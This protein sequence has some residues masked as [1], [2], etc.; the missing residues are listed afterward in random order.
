MSVLNKKVVK[1]VFLCLLFLLCNTA[2]SASIDEIKQ[3]IEA[4]AQNKALLEKEIEQYQKLLKEIGGEVDTLSKAIKTIEATE[5]KTL[6]D[7]KLTENNINQ[8]E[9]EI[10]RLAY[11]IGGKEKDIQADSKIVYETLNEINQIDSSSIIIQLLSQDNLSS[12]WSDM[13]NFYIIQNKIRDKLSELKDTKKA[14]EINKK[15]T[16][17]KKRELTSLKSDL[18]DKKAIL[19]ISKKEKNKLLANTKNKESNY[20]TELDKKTALKNAFD[21]ELAQF[22]S[23]LKFA[24]DPNSIPSAGKGILSW[25]LDNVYITQKFGVTSDSGRLYTTG[26][27]NGVDF[28]AS[29]GT[30]VKATLSGIVEGVGDTDLVCSGASYGK[31]ILIT[32]NNGLSTLYG[33]LS[34]IKVK[35]G[36]K[37]FTGDTI[38]YSGSTG[39][40]TGP[41]LHL[42]LFAS[43]G[44]KIMSKKSAVCKG[45]YTLPMADMRAY[46]DPLSYL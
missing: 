17:D 38:G 45:T 23:E 33:H 46:L 39:Y 42:G 44:V 2:Y 16:E 18:L 19:E 11:D 25:P 22:E 37:V 3:K 27:H 36:D 7:I 13:E 8:A 40:S 24:I 43:Q 26:S 34:L 12:F 5:K 15:E 21:K 14:L 4:T 29:V 20:K 28:R 32:H 1:Y 41:H 9:L 10:D 6:L 35:A 30:K 31:W